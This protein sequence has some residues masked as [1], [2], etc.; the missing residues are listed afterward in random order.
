MNLEQVGHQERQLVIELH[1]QLSRSISGDDELSGGNGDD[2]ETQI[3]GRMKDPRSDRS[4]L[5]TR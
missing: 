4:G 3:G 2:D 5:D 1:W